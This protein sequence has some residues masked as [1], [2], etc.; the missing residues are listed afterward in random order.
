MING[1]DF[2]TFIVMAL[3]SVFSLLGVILIIIKHILAFIK[4][5]NFNSGV[6]EYIFII[7]CLVFQYLALPWWLTSAA[8]NMKDYAKAEGFYKAAVKTALI[9]SVKAFAYE[10]LAYYYG[11]RFEGQKSIDAFVKSNAIKPNP[12]N[13]AK[14]CLLYSFKGDTE[15]AINSCL[16]SESYRLAAVNYSMTK[17]YKK[18]LETLNKRFDENPGCWDY[19]V[20]G[21]IYG[22]A[23]DKNAFKK[24]TDKALEMCPDYK[25][26]RD[27]T[28]NPD[29]YEKLFA[30]NKKKY[31]F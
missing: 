28:K 17:N 13:N 30:K 14:L 19:A 2:L 25:Q 22:K 1:D 5:K 18:A 27:F 3:L 7:V 11:I 6:V 8:F 24:D 4:T 21:Y 15:N 26:L 9:P 29:Y 23:G 20:R 31:K 12:G 16:N 10:N